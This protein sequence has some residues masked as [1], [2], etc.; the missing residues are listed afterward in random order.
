VSEGVPCLS[1]AQTTGRPTLYQFVRFL[2]VGGSFAGIYILCTTLLLQTSPTACMGSQCFGL[3][4]VYCS[5]LLGSKTVCI[6]ISCTRNSNA[7]PRYLVLQFA[8]LLFASATAGAMH[9][10]LAS[11]RAVYFCGFD[12]YCCNRQFFPTQIMGTCRL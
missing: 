4:F 1:F 10:I 7:F 12:W 6:P 9:S 11:A 5:C 8:S 3:W 2:F